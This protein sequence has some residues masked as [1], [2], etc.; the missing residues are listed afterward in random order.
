MSSRLPVVPLAA[1]LALVADVPA[2][3]ATS[4][5]ITLRASDGGSVTG[6]LWEPSQR[7][8]PAVLLLPMQTRTRDDWQ[9]LAAKL[10]DAGFVVLAI[11]LRGF[12]VPVLDPRIDSAPLLADVA[13]G[14]DALAS[15][16]DLRPG[17]IGL[18]GA[19]I[20]ANL[21][22]LAAAA[23]PRVRSLALLSP[24]LEYRGVRIEAPMKKY[25][26]P[27]LIVASTKDAYALRSMRELAHEAPGLREQRGVE[28]AAHGTALLLREPD[29]ATV[30]VDWFKRTL[31]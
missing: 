14:L 19:S 15:R 30:L 26:E 11:D 21:A 16:P 9:P 2:R 27:A 12:G 28:A 4:H 7:P 23:D 8:A 13:A 31:P 24:G 3:A 6:T 17:A 20:G 5:A 18:A 10:V 1:L 22:V 25:A 29:L